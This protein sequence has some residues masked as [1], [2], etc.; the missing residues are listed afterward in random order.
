VLH[1][2]LAPRH[3]RNAIRHRLGPSALPFRD[4]APA[5]RKEC[6]QAEPLSRIGPLVHRQGVLEAHQAK[7][8]DPVGHPPAFRNARAQADPAVAIIKLLS[9]ANVPA[10]AYLRLNQENPYTPASL[11]RVVA[12]HSS[13]SATP[14]VN[15]SCIPCVRD[16]AQ[17]RVAEPQRSHLLKS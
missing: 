13:R 10:R 14:K 1:G 7:A 6:A 9:A 3:Q 8:Q 16:P 2:P 4:N 15:A 11:Q 5:L 17:V 12:V